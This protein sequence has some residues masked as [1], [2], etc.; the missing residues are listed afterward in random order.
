V[1]SYRIK[2]EISWACDAAVTAVNLQREREKTATG[3]SV[4]EQKR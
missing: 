1:T 2:T 4:V 3:Q